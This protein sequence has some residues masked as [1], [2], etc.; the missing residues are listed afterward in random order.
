MKPP[1]TEATATSGPGE[2][3]SKRVA[4]MLRCSRSQAEQY[5]EGGWVRV[6]GKV[7]ES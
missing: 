1:T 2:R 5:I 6:A 3:L 7:V 4:Q